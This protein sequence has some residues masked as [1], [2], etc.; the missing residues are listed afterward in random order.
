MDNEEETI[1]DEEYRLRRKWYVL[2]VKPRTEKKVAN[3]LSD[4]KAWHF[5][6]LFTKVRKVQRRKVRTQLPLFPGYVIAKLDFNKRLAI[7]KTNLVVKAIPVFAPRL[8]IHQLRQVMHA[9]RRAP[10]VKTTKI[11]K[12]GQFVKIKFGPFMGTEGYVKRTRGKTSLVL[13]VDILGTAV[14]VDVP[15]QY[16]E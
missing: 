4:Y 9:L 7:L 11:Y 10:L 15:P 8:M 6:P 14:E 5:L 12:V 16:C 1:A 3:Y 2:H 13:N